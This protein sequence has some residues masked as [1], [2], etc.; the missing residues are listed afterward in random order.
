MP[1]VFEFHEIFEKEIVEVNS[2]RTNLKRDPVALEKE[3]ADRYGNPVLR[4]TKPSNLAGLALSGGGIR[5]ASF[6]LGVLQALNTLDLLKKID[7]LSTVSGGGY[8]GTSMCAAMS[9][10]K[11]DKFPFASELAADEPAGL[12]HLRDYSN[13]LFPR[14]S[15]VFA[16]LIRNVVVYMRGV[17]FSFL[18]VLPF[19]LFFA[20]ITIALNRDA[21]GLATPSLIGITQL[22]LGIFGNWQIPL[23]S[24]FRH[25]AIAFDT[26]IIFLGFLAV[27][28]IGRSANINQKFGE[29]GRPGAVIAS[30]LLL[31]VLVAIFTDAQKYILAEM[32]GW[33]GDGIQ[34]QKWFGRV[35]AF[36]AAFSAAMGFLASYAAQILKKGLEDPRLRARILRFATQVAIYVAA[37]A[38]PFLL[39]VAYLYLSLWGLCVGKCS[40]GAGYYAP[41]FVSS[42]GAFFGKYTGYYLLPAMPSP[43]QIYVVVTIVLA[44]LLLIYG[45][46]ANTLHRLY[47]DR[48]SKAFIF[49]PSKFEEVSRLDMVNLTGVREANVRD[50]E[51]RPQDLKA[52]DRLKLSEIDCRYP[53]YQVINAAL[54]IGGSKYANRRGRNADFF[55][56][57]P[58]YTGSRATRYVK[59]TDLEENSKDLD[60]ATAMA[61]SG[62]AASSNMGSNTIRA[63]TPTLTLL[64]VRLGFWLTNPTALAK[65]RVGASFASAFEVFYF[66]RELLGLLREDDGRIYLTD[67]GHVENL[68]IYE[69]LH[70]RCRLIIAVDAEAD[71]KM[72]FTSLM[73]LERHA[74]IDL[75][76]RID[77]PWAAIRDVSRKTGAEVAESGGMSAAAAPHGP[78]CAIGEIEYP[79]KQK[80][81]LFYIKSS[82][83]GDEN[84]GIIDHKRRFPD[85]PHETTADQFFSEEQFEVYRALGFH[86]AMRALN[87]EDLVAVK[88]KAQL[89]KRGKN[90]SVNEVLDILD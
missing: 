44:V 89:F 43:L 17:L 24:N 28:G 72:N 32:I 14:G 20:T 47:R 70:R 3:G 68:G 87:G 58:K 9:A 86:A 90:A 11:T 66:I 40:A 2:R 7:Y 67:G 34:V 79:D 26:L 19:L 78:H 81:V 88:P 49:D 50:E 65:S 15:T 29:I 31:L 41:A 53:P 82:L 73:A 59:T 21:D 39:W 75:G 77:L 60:V 61:V 8:I 30:V 69:L 12:Q 6:C 1:K 80:G 83:S 64:N 84:D 62:A 63:L 42:I 13:Y 57:S 33:Q 35:T 52:M 55:M 37:A 5:S 85:F 27:W 76:V 46:N 56:F 10:A 74:L 4:P 54:N 16:N 36:F 18:L 51:R 45:P 25:F 38:L 48:L 23:F 22:Q 71:D